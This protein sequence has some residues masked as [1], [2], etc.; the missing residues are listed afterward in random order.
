MQTA[1]PS[2]MYVHNCNYWTISGPDVATYVQQQYPITQGTILSTTQLANGSWMNTFQA[3]AL[4]CWGWL[5][6]RDNNHSSS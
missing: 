2:L 6:A 4:L 1:S 3:C 5:V